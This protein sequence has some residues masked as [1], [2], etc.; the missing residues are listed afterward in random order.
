MQRAIPKSF[1]P[2]S[3]P[4]SSVIDGP[5]L[6]LGIASVGE[7]IVVH[8]VVAFSV[9]LHHVVVVVIVAAATANVVARPAPSTRFPSGSGGR[10]GTEVDAPGHLSQL[11]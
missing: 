1:P 5:H 2:P 6:L 10:V 11:A 8:L 9:R 7:N 3:R 4:A